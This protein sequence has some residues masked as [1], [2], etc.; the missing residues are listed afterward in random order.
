M[1]EL[2]K[3]A[4]ISRSTFYRSFETKEMFFQWVL[5]FHMEG[6]SGAAKYT[7]NTPTVFYE[8]YFHYLYEHAIY[9]KTFNSSSMWP[10]FHYRM[11]QIGIEVYQTFIYSKIQ[12]E[13]VSRLISHYIINAHIGVAMAWLNEKNL[14]PPNKV[15]QLVATMTE[16]AL[17]SQHI[18]LSEIFPYQK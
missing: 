7:A 4:G 10:E 6:L 12:N 16:Q 11:T 3:H 2:I 13:K 14:Q 15:A 17:A 18:V 9:F 1:S 5:D 8:H